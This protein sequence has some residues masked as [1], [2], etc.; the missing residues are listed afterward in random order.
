MYRFEPDVLKNLPIIYL[1][2]ND[3]RNKKYRNK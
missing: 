2:K 3:Y 1:S